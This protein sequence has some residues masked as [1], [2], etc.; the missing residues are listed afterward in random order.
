VSKGIKTTRRMPE[1][2]NAAH[3]NFVMLALA[4]MF[5]DRPTQSVADWC[6]ENLRFDEPGNNGPFTL[7]GAEYLRE[8]L[9]CWADPMISDQVLVFGSQSKKT[10]SIMGGASWTVRNEPSRIVWV[11]PTRDLVRK[12]SRTRWIP[13]VRA[14]PLLAELVPTG[15]RRNDFSTLEQQIGS[16]IIDFVWSNSPAALSSNPARVVILDEV[17]KFNEGGGKESNAV[18]LAAQ[19]TKN[20]GSPK[21]VKTSTPTIVEGL[22]WQ[23]LL[24]TD[25]RRRFMPC[26]HCSKHVLLAWSKQFTVF[27]ILGCEA[28]V[29][30]DAEARRPNGSWDLDRVERSARYECP[31]CGGHINDS[32]KTRMDREGEWRPTQTAARGYRGWHLPSLYAASPETSVG[33]LA[34]KFLQAKQGLLGLQGFINGDLA[35]PMEGQDTRRERVE[36][37]VRGDENPIPAEGFQ[38][39][40]TVDVQESAPHFFFIRQLWSPD[41]T[42]IIEA[43][44]CMTYEELREIQLKH[45][46]PDNYVCVDSGDDTQTVYSNCARFGELQMTSQRRA[47]KLPPLHVGWIPSKGISSE[48]WMVNK[49]KVLARIQPLERPING[50]IIA[51]PLLE[52]ADKPIK[53]ILDRLRRGRASVRWEVDQAVATEDFWTHLD[54]ERLAKFWDKRT[55]RVKEEWVRRSSHWPNHW[56]DCAKLQV[57]LAIF[58]RL[59]V[60][61][62]PTTQRDP[63]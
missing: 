6:C 2:L 30:W 32:H 46:I 48:G 52:F 18:E 35:E 3:H 19:R 27:P 38:Q 24:K 1:P 47:N 20:F 28:F 42:R 54:G 62:V 29:R 17:D 21:R 51:L 31:H 40:L 49:S 4:G 11:M 60:E 26:P 56:F 39:L 25:L 23:E 50:R 45:K 13:M 34:V 14:S 33:K 36:I 44:S 58:H 57:A 43:G 22:I 9:D 53:D 12:F 41:L 16:S 61:N 59:L 55:N 5:A 7:S 8:P 15:A 37:I 10:G 63:Q